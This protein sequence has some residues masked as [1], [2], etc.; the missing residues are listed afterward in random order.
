V[1]PAALLGVGLWLGA[2]GVV[3]SAHQT[4]LV[5]D[6]VRTQATL[7]DKQ[8]RTHSRVG[9]S[10]PFSYGFV[11]PGSDI[12][13]T[14]QVDDCDLYDR[15]EIGETIP[16]IYSA[17][18]PSVN[19]LGDPHAAASFFTAASAWWLFAIPGIGRVVAFLRS[20]R[21]ARGTTEPGVPDLVTQLTP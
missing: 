9:Y 10:C 8:P 20:R 16:I 12:T 6:G 2:T 15:L 18:E 21:L 11:E 7:I 3:V 4:L 17:S 14:N 1:H 5:R 13:Y 19:Q